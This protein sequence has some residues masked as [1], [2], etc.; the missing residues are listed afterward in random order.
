MPIQT[1][2]CFEYSKS[3]EIRSDLEITIIPH[4]PFLFLFVIKNYMNRGE[5]SNV[6]DEQI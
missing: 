6:L 2:P 3:N 5:I 1:I 4:L